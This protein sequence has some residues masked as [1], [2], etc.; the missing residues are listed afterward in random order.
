MA[1]S[2]QTKCS[3]RVM[4][5]LLFLATSSLCFTPRSVG[6]IPSLRKHVTSRPPVLMVAR[7]INPMQS[8]HFF[9]KTLEHQSDGGS[10]GRSS[11]LELEILEEEEKKKLAGKID[12][13]MARI[14]WLLVSGGIAKAKTMYGEEE[15]RLIMNKVE[16]ALALARGKPTSFGACVHTIAKA[17]AVYGEEVHTIA[18]AKAVC[19]EEERR[20]I[21][22]KV[23]HALALARRK[24]TSFGARVHAK[25]EL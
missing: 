4:V 3:I 20:S 24:P 15:R 19:G 1:L 13:T 6:P 2:T 25:G 11:L 22:N 5:S 8:H 14:K 23:E 10:A 7:P 17:K 21:L 16:H 12:I 9:S 18:K